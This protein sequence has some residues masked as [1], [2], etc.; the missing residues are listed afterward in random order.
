MNKEEKY[1]YKGKTIIR[2]HDINP[3]EFRGHYENQEGL[4]FVFQYKEVKRIR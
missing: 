3:W 1:K 4:S 2:T